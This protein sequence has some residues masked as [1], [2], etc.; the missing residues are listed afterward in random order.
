LPASVRTRE[1]ARSARPAVLSESGPASW[2]ESG[3]R[4]PLVLRYGDFGVE[5]VGSADR[6]AAGG[7]RAWLC[8]SVR[9]ETFYQRSVVVF[10]ITYFN[11]IA[12]AYNYCLPTYAHEICSVD[13]I[14]K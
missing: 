13:E 8:S 9:L 2:R 7:R 10:Y 14:C 1:R 5:N 11:G 4:G 3:R 6:T 12:Y